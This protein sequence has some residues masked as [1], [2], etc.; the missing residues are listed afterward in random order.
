MVIAGAALIGAVWVERRIPD[1]VLDS[2]LLYNRVFA[3]A[4]VSLMMALL[5]LFAVGFLLP[6][7]FE[8]LRGY[9]TLHSGLLLTPFSL[10]FAVVAPLAG[11]LADRVGSWWL[12]PVGLAIAC[13]G[14]LLLSG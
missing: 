2:A 13:A 14:L 9:D 6:F 10:T 1:P 7:Y 4:N 12:A 8:E 5:A 3:S 11:R